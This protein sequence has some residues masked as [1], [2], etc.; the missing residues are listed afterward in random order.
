MGRARQVRP[1]TLPL[2]ARNSAAT[3]L[4]LK[5]GSIAYGQRE[6]RR[7][8]H[9]GQRGGVG[10]VHDQLDRNIGPAQTRAAKKIF[11]VRN[12]IEADQLPTQRQRSA[13]R[14]REARH[15]RRVQ[16]HR[17]ELSTIRAQKSTAAIGHTVSQIGVEVGQAAAPRAQRGDGRAHL[18]QFIGLADGRADEAEGVDPERSR[19]HRLR[20]HGDVEGEPVSRKRRVA[21]P[22]SAKVILIGGIVVSGRV[23][24]SVIEG[25]DGEGGAV[26]SA[27][28][29]A[30][31]EPGGTQPEHRLRQGGCF[32]G[33]VSDLF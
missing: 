20:E 18:T 3:N 24:P 7:L 17:D 14:R 11:G 31:A 33:N 5:T 27:G 26:R 6:A 8:L 25:V 32:H 12:P 22:F 29:Q 21:A 1:G 10:V 28:G 15:K 23:I 16:S 30:G 2:V 9:D 4:H 13:L 19:G